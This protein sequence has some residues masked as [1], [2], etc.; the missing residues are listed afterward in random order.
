MKYIFSLLC[1]FL[2]GYELELDDLIDT[3]VVLSTK[4]IVLPECPD[5]FNPSIIEK[6]DGYILVFRYAPNAYWDPWTNYI[7][8]VLL[9]SSF[10]PVS[11]PELI[12]SDL[13]PSHIQSQAEDA[14]I[15]SY[16]GRYYLIYN[17][18]V[19]QCRPWYGDRRDI[20][21]AELQYDGAHFKL[22]DAKKLI[23][24]KKY[25][26]NW[27][28][29]WTP[30]V[31]QNHLLLSYSISPHEILFPNMDDGACFSL[32]VTDLPTGWVL[33]L[34]RGSSAA[35][36][37]DGEYFAFFHAGHQI[38]SSLFPDAANWHYF[39]GAYTFSAEPPFE[40]TKITPRPIVGKDFYTPSHH[41]KKVILPGGFVIKEDRIFV[42]Y[43]KN[44]DEMWIAE[45]NKKALLDSLVQVQ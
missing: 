19:E 5:A 37:V 1:I 10:N 38:T 17:D 24:E 9:D 41:Y 35:V 15:F 7:G 16:Q 12:K 18:N 32:Y 13:Y 30:F 22:G 36:L 39:M 3:K 25:H 33:G 21:I 11:T 45:L 6:D 27:Q 40:L 26:A 43:G 44:D 14:R 23:Y 4:Q 8:V 29:N 20:Y 2:F 34:L 28:K 42:A 31:Y